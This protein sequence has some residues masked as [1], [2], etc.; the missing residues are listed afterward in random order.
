[1]NCSRDDASEKKGKYQ[2][3]NTWGPGADN[4]DASAADEIQPCKFTSLEDSLFDTCEYM[5]PQKPVDLAARDPPTSDS[6]E[7]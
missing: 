7:L 3:P 4:K 1:M 5:A 6:L 2:E